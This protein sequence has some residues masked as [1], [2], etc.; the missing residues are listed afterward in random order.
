MKGPQGLWATLLPL[1][2][3]ARRD[4]SGVRVDRYLE[5][6]PDL[7]DLAQRLVS[8]GTARRFLSMAQAEAMA[9]VWDDLVRLG[10]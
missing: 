2:E 9:L 7:A 5:A 8:D 10:R 6:V 4:P 1:L 3:R